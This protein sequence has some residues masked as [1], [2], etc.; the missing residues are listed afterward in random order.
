MTIAALIANIW[1][2]GITMKQ[3]RMRFSAMD[4]LIKKG[5][6]ENPLTMN[7]EATEAEAK[8]FE[9]VSK[10]IEENNK[11]GKPYDYNIPRVQ[12]EMVAKFIT[13]FHKIADIF[14]NEQL[15]RGNSPV[16]I[17]HY[18]QSIKKMK[19]FFCWMN[20]DAL[21]YDKL[22]DDE[23]V[24]YG[25]AQPYAVFERDDFEA[26]YRKFLIDVEDVSDITVATYFR[27]YR[28]IAYWMMDRELIR[29][30]NI[31][32]RNVEAEIKDVYTDEEISRLLK[33]PKDDCSFAEYRS[34]V[35]INWVLATGNRCA[36]ICSIKIKDIDFEEDMININ[37]QK[38]KR[39][40]RIPL[41]K[42]LRNILIDYIEDWLVDDEGEYIT[43]YLFP[44]S[45]SLSFNKPM[46]RASMGRAIAD[47]N[48]SR[49]VAKTSIHLFRH[50]FAKNW[51]MSGG[52]LHSL[53]RILGHSTLDM[54]T[55]YANL[56]GEDLKPKVANYSVLA[57]H[58]QK[59]SGKMIKRR[60]R[61]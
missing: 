53:Q 27:D 59:T 45:Y 41:E 20:A 16:T 35:I 50:T 49:G 13:P 32:I 51:I 2:G 9:A 57:T 21:R 5:N 12:L 46:E 37:T 36:T 18:K 8:A 31:V 55:K 30:H 6:R 7:I 19:K 34:W 25:A 4:E 44:N 58:K 11:N 33:K 14:I 29:K 38:S 39:V 24:A 15:G 61:R 10:Q 28:A 40:H 43:E 60:N 47:Y 3:R 22:T 17:T 52:D 26:L 1:K 23:R 42:K 54:V 48:K 56:Y